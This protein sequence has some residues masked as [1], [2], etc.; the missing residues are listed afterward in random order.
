MNHRLLLEDGCISQTD[1]DLLGKE[2]SSESVSS[3]KRHNN[4][5]Q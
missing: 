3:I 4:D 1:I 5:N 2:Q